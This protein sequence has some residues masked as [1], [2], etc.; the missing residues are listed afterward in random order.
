MDYAHLNVELV[1]TLQTMVSKG[2]AV[3][4]LVRNLRSASLPALLEYGCLRFT[5]GEAIPELPQVVSS[6]EAW[7]SLRCISSPLGLSDSGTRKSLIKDV[8]PRPIEFTTVL[9]EVDT[10]EVAWENYLQ[11][12]ESS[13]KAAGFPTDTALN[14][15]SA[16]HEMATN[17][18]I[19]SQAS[20]PALVGYA[21]SKNCA[22]FSV[23]DVGQGIAATLRRNPKY[24][25]LAEPVDAI[26]KAL[27]SGITCRADD[28]GGF[29]FSTIFKAVAEA[30]GQLRF[31]SGNG[32]ITMDGTELEVD[33]SIRRFPPPLPGFQVSVCCH[34]GGMVSA[35]F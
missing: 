33:K 30:W 21:V 25:H 32:C 19:H 2:K 20:V 12:F 22:M 18:V 7:R 11:R 26:R 14:L 3:A 29:G 6:S 24:V 16:L 23:V 13:A 4:P 15:Q 10:T 1:E 8:S 34:A 9:D 28:S 17:A 31:R 35:A 5:L 27:E